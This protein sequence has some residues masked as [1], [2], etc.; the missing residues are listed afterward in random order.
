MSDLASYCITNIAVLEEVYIYV[1]VSEV[2][3][4][5]H[6]SYSIPLPHRFLLKDK[7]ENVNALEAVTVAYT[8]DAAKAGLRTVDWTMD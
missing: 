4:R 5:K 8:Q 6:L 2:L 1:H 3:Q 7:L